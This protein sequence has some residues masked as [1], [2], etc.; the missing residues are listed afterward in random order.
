MVTRKNQPFVIWGSA[1]LLFAAT[2][3]VA[4]PGTLIGDNIRQLQEIASGQI[5]DWHSPFHSTVWALFGGKTAPMLVFQ[6]LVYWTGIAL[7]A[8]A[9]ARKAGLRWGLA[10]LAVGLTPLSIL[11]MARIQKDN[12]VTAWLILAV[13]LTVKFGRAYGLLPAIL[14][15]LS[16]ANAVFAV[17]PLFVSSRSLLRTVALCVALALALI[18]LSRLINY[19]VLGAKPSNVEKSLQ[20]FDLAGIETFSGATLVQPSLERCYTPFWWDRLEIEC[21]AFTRSRGSLTSVWLKAIAD[22]P[23]AYLWHRARAFNSNIHFLVPA[24][25]DCIATANPDCVETDQA[26]LKD[27]LTRNPLLWPVTWLLVGSLL[28]FTRLEGTAR[29]LILSG[30][31]YGFAYFAFGVAAGIRYFYW[32]EFAIQVGIVWQ[33]AIGGIPRW[34]RIALAVAAVWLAGLAFR[35]GPLALQ[36]MV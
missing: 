25:Q 27:A 35:Y 1:A 2:I 33:L 34:R 5:S 14:G 9:L 11:Y 22:H 26:L 3:A 36:A 10:L 32:T 20:L 19:D 4:W 12:F 29:A 28:L 8:N 24:R 6:A 21:R 30:L 23:A 17:P 16:R 18:P 31:L 15:M 13:G 7:L